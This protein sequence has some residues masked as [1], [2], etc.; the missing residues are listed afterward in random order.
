VDTILLGGAHV[1]AA[2]TYRLSTLFGVALLFTILLAPSAQADT[3][4]SALGVAGPSNY[5][6]LFLSTSGQPQMNGPGTTTG[7]VGYNG[8]TNLQ[9]NGSNGPEINGNLILG[10]NATV[11]NPGQVT[12]TIFTNQS[13]Q[14]NAAQAAA[15]SAGAFFNGLTPTSVLTSV[16]GTATI[17]G[18]AGLN[19]I[20]LT[21]INLGNGQTLTLNGPAG[22]Q[23]VI[24]VSG[25]IV[26]NSALIQ[27]TGGLLATDVVFNVGGKVQTSGGLN[28][29]SV[30][31]GIVL[32]L[33]GQI[34]MAPGAI[35]GELIAGGN[36]PQIVSGGSVHGVTNVPE[37]S[38]LLLLSMGVTGLLLLRRRAA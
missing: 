35:N 31:N 4:S 12:G 26:L 28:N 2:T 37:P 18:T 27:E 29:L 10:N 14:L 17:I 13:A 1:T 9:L 20:D 34:A 5:A 11:N 33:T 32:D 25:D 22:A 7:N 19:V 8:S 23:F 16:N 3:I 38:S 30:I 21:G 6:I 36:N 24:N 15:I